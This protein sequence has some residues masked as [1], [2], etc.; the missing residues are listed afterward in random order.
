MD[1]AWKIGIRVLKLGIEWS[2][3]S[4]DRSSIEERV[5]EMGGKLGECD[6]STQLVAVVRY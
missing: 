3:K 2:V 1:E 6:N 5:R 4:L